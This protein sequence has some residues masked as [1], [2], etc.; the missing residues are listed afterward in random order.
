LR[1]IIYLASEKQFLAQGARDGAHRT[2]AL[3]GIQSCCGSKALVWQLSVGEQQRVEIVSYYSAA[4][5]LLIWDEPTAVLT[6]QEAEGAVS[7]ASEDGG[8]GKILPLYHSQAF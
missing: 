3:G 1:K 2:G 6:P 7:T 5:K 8:G 4:Q